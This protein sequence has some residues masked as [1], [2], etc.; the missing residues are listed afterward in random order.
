MTRCLR[1][2]HDSSF[3]GAAGR[4]ANPAVGEAGGRRRRTVAKLAPRARATTATVAPFSAPS[5]RP[6]KAPIRDARPAPTGA[7]DPL[8][9]RPEDPTRAR[10]R[11]PHHPAPVHHETASLHQPSSHHKTSPITHRIPK[12]QAPSPLPHITQN[13]PLKPD[14][15]PPKTTPRQPSPTPQHQP[16]TPKKILHRHFPKAE[17]GPGGDAV[18]AIRVFPAAEARF[19]APG[20]AVLGGGSEGR[21][22]G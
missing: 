15:P 12:P 6:G 13:D 22:E 9:N 20:S 21:S 18:L 10:Q 5:P 7:T 1:T 19:R 17:T 3:A 8:R 16:E 4:P 14:N 2:S 11:P